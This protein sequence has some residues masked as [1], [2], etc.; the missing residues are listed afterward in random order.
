MKFNS[1]MTNSYGRN[2]NIKT[3]G[4]EMFRCSRMEG[5]SIMILPITSRGAVANCHIEIPMEEIDEFIHQLEL[6]KLGSLEIQ[7]PV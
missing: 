4:I 6:M 3:S 5:K 7:E 2:G 1:W